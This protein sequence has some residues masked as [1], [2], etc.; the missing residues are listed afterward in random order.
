MYFNMLVNVIEN[1]DVNLSISMSF[2]NG[3][4]KKL[5]LEKVIF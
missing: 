2:I 4:E 5:I 1:V 3:L